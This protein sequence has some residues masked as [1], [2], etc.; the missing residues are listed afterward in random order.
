MTSQVQ[1]LSFEV[2]SEMAKISSNYF[3]KV[4][5]GFILQCSTYSQ[6]I[7]NNFPTLK[8]L[9]KIYDWKG[10]SLLSLYNHITFDLQICLRFLWNLFYWFLLCALIRNR[11]IYTSPTRFRKRW[12]LRSM[13]NV[14][15]QNLKVFYASNNLSKDILCARWDLRIDYTPGN[16]RKFFSFRKLQIMLSDLPFNRLFVFHW[17]SFDFQFF[18]TKHMNK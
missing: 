18:G 4:F 1:S 5:W 6:V 9:S 14:H 3:V 7:T 12:M 13:R 2:D 16:L 8:S 10:L 17:F 15:R 11:I